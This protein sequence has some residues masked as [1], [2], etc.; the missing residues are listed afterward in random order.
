MIRLTFR[1][2]VNHVDWRSIESMNKRALKVLSRAAGG[3][4]EV[5]GVEMQARMKGIIFNFA[6]SIFNIIKRCL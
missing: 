1:S 4:V 2:I 3:P 5:T 6:F